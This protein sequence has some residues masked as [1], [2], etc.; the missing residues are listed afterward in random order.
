MLEE[1]EKLRQMAQQALDPMAG[2]LRLGVIPT[3]GPYLLPH[4]VPQLRKDYPQLQLY[5]RE[6]LTGNL[7][8][9]LRTGSLD[10]ILVAFPIQTDGLELIEMFR[11]PFVMALP[12]DSPLAGQ[13]RGNGN[14]PDGRPPVAARGRALPA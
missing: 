12:K 3:L 7:I 9:R 5:L 2:M 4:L 11:E 1:A 13:G 6:D 10:A 8:E 14:G